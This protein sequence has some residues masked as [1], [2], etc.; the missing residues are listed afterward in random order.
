MK[1]FK[2]KFINKEAKNEYYRLLK[3]NRELKK[4]NREFLDSMIATN[5]KE[6]YATLLAVVKKYNEIIIRNNGTMYRLS[7]GE[8]A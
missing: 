4:F 3:Q 6:E 2:T 5:D 1:L 8:A 7:N